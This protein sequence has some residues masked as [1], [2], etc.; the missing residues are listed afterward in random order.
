VN[1]SGA[2]STTKLLNLEAPN[3]IGTIT[4][5]KSEF[6]IQRITAVEDGSPLG[7]VSVWNLAET[8]IITDFSWTSGTPGTESATATNKTTLTLSNGQL[9]ANYG[10]KINNNVVTGTYVNASATLRVYDARL[11]IKANLDFSN[12]KEASIQTI[13]KIDSLYCGADG[14]ANSFTGGSGAADTGLEAH[15]DLLFRFAGFDDTDANIYN[16]DAS[17]DIEA[18]RITSAWNIR[19]W[20]LEPIELK[21][22]LERIQYEFGFIFK[23]RHDGT[24]SYWYI[25]DSYSSGDV[26][27]TFTKRDI[28]KLKISNTPFSQLLTKMEISYEK[29]PAENRYLSTQT[30]EDTTNNPRSIWNIQSKENIKEI[31]LDMNVNKPGNTNVGGNDPNDG[32]ADYYMNIFGDIKKMITCQVINPAVSYNLETGDIVQFSNTAGEMPV[33]PFGDNWADYYMI[34]NLNRSPGKVSITCREVG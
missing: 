27:Q 7:I 16:Y 31:N 10:C 28:S 12:N 3:I 11:Y 2:V 34:I 29:H 8:D 17:L 21:K 32:F 30:S 18:T 26:A 23:W 22:V 25:K 9:P 6:Y 5:G 33:D 1:S 14:L 15:R 19:W 13:D 24:G 20:A 4:E